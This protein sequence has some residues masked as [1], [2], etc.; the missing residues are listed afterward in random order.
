MLQLACFA[1]TFS[2]DVG[3]NDTR[4]LSTVLLTNFSDPL[5][6]LFDVELPTNMTTSFD[7]AGMVAATTAV[8]GI[9]ALVDCERFEKV[10]SKYLYEPT[11]SLDF[12]FMS[13]GAP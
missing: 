3:A 2:P 4:K 9:S 13:V 1:L 12:T 6:H 10:T 11:T 7:P 8:R 5:F